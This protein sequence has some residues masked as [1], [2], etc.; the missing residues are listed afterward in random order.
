MYF[1][2][3]SKK[4]HNCGMAK[5]ATQGNLNPSNIGSSPISAVKDTIFKYA[6]VAY[7]VGALD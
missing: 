4:I 7:E 6:L 1:T 5:L 2:Q 3:I